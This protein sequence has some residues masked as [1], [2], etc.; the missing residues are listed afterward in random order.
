MTTSSDAARQS[1]PSSLAASESSPSTDSLALL[2]SLRSR[3]PSSIKSFFRALPIV[4]RVESRTFFNELNEKLPQRGRPLPLN[5]LPRR[6]REVLG[7]CYRSR[8]EIADKF[9]TP[10]APP[11]YTDVQ[12]RHERDILVDRVRHRVDRQH[13]CANFIQIHT[14]QWL[15]KPRGPMMRKLCNDIIT[16]FFEYDSVDA[17]EPSSVC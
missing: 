3:N 9:G 4:D 6:L 16:D 2:P 12:F 10:P 8:I 7:V 13:Q 15:Y 17:T 14:L 1:M 11:R 5:P